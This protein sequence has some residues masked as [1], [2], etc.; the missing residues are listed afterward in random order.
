M[1]QVVPGIRK[2]ELRARRYRLLHYI[3]TDTHKRNLNIKSHVVVIPSSHKKFMSEKIPYVFRQNTDFLYLTGCMEQDSVLV[4][5]AHGDCNY[6]S[7]LFLKERNANEEIFD[8]PR[9]CPDQAVELFGVEKS[10]PI[11]HL[12]GFLYSFVKENQDCGL[13]YDFINK[14]PA[15]PDI[16]KKMNTFFSQIWNKVVFS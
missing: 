8:G 1:F 16:H 2:E 11:S 10:L 5:T 9:T 4:L 3:E 15:H 13:W 14:T 7:I 12:E 6:E